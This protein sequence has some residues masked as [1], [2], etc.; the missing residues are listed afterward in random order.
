[1]MPVA[2]TYFSGAR[3]SIEYHLSGTGAEARAKA[4]LVC[5]DQTV[6][7]PDEIIPSGVI[8][9]CILGRVERF[10][11]LCANR[12]E[13]TISYPVEL[14]RNDCS[15]LL[16]VA[17]GISSL[18]PGVRVARLHLPDAVL[19][20][21][22]GARFGRNGLRELVGVPD[23]PLVCGVLKPLGLSVAALAE[24][25]YQFALGG[26]DLIKDDQGLSDHAFCP[27]EDR[28]ARCAEAVA[29]ANQETGRRCL[30]MPHVSGP[31]EAMRA[32]CLFAKKAG[33]GGVLICPGVTGF[34]GLRGI[35]QDAAIALPILSH[36]ALL[37]SFIMPADSGIAPSVLFGQIPRLAGADV[38]IYPTFGLDFP[39]SRDDCRQIAVET[40]MPWGS[41]KPIFPTAAGRMSVERIGEMCAFYGNDLVFIL[42]SGIQRRDS[43]LVKA[44]RRFVDEIA[45]CARPT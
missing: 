35:A 11:R 12:Y 26:L 17:F 16:N 14:I 19:P 37:G 44:C 38:S 39:L 2:P 40:G 1:M 42:G 25:A 18:K 45:R 31:W 3:F 15:H 9:D 30:Y 29:K 7:A 28:V 21:W 6:E 24:L 27:F 23:R 41:L 32:R 8:R 33:A 34:D 22:F 4:D 10:R 5:I 13:A 43:H 36:P 20:Q